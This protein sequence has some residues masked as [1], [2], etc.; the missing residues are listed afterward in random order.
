MAVMIQGE[1]LP[2]PE[3]HESLTTE[4]REGIAK[5]VTK[6]FNDEAQI[7]ADRDVSPPSYVEDRAREIQAEHWGQMGGNE[8]F[9]W[10]SDN[11]PD[12]LG[13]VKVSGTGEISKED[14]D[15]LLKLANSDDPKAIWAIADSQWGKRLLL[16]TDWTGTLNLKD[17]ETM[18]RFN[19]YVGKQR[20]A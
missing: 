2:K 13:E 20:A 10:A 6:A 1:L 5:A 8:K 19:A 12:V 3:P 9:G 7:D 18:D 11:A 14:E 4:M 16:D 17:K 15:R